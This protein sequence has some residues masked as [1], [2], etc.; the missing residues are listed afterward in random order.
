[1]ATS[2]S[3]S[4]HFATTQW[5]LVA[6]AGEVARPDAREALSQLCRTYWLPVYA[7]VRSRT[8]SIEEAHDLTQE[9]FC[10]MLEQNLVAKADPER[11]RFRSFLLASVKNFLANEWD[12]SQR[13]KRGGDREIL[14]LDFA[15][16]DSQLAAE[17]LDR[18]SPEKLFE[19]QWALTLIGVVLDQ[20]RTDYST[21]DKLDQFEALKG[22]LIGSGERVSAAEIAAQLGMTDDAVRQAMHRL[23]QRFREL[24]YEEVGRTVASKAEIDD[25][26]RGLFSSLGE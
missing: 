18:Q 1:M 21:R 24:L 10:R 13:Q 25:E 22:C 20:L 23:R 15:R 9:F 8:P 3:P 19:R 16:G 17:P 4:P 2:G 26:I 12:K 5:S 14:S 7:F 6:A 11:G